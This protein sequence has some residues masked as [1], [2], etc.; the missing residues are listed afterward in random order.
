M[1]AITSLAFMLVEVP[2]PPWYQSTWNWS[3]Y[4]P[5]SKASAAFWMAASVS[6][7][8]APTS[9]LARAAASLTSAQASMKPG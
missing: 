6:A 3:W 5:A 2:A 1:L 7:S 9:W 4:W 8:S